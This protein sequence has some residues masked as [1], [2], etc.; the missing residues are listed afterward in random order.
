VQEPVH[1]YDIGIGRDIALTVL[2]SVLTLT[3]LY[4]II[5]K[6]APPIV[7]LWCVGA[8]WSIVSIWKA[9]RRILV[10]AEERTIGFSGPAGLRAFPL[11]DL[12]YIKSV[13]VRSYLC[14]GLKGA[15]VRTSADMLR[16]REMLRLLA[17]LGCVIVTDKLRVKDSGLP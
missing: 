17:N 3:V 11:S 5:M 2:V 14:F 1:V 6:N 9:P 8:A 16:I 12:I 4:Q 15:T 13:N 10:N 7:G